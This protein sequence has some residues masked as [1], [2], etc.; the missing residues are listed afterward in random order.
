MLPLREPCPADQLRYVLRY[1][2]GN[3]FRQVLGPDAF[4]PL[5]WPA[6]HDSSVPGQNLCPI[7]CVR[8]MARGSGD[9][10]HFAVDPT[11]GPDQAVGW[12]SLPPLRRL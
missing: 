3:A 8:K 4:L 12:A 9:Y 11:P 5:G 2:G 10:A 1:L 7:S 6:C